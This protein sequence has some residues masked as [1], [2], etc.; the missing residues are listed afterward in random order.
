M[1]IS[2]AQKTITSNYLHLT[3]NKWLLV[4]QLQMLCHAGDNVEHA[5]QMPFLY[6]FHRL[7]SGIW[8][9]HRLNHGYTSQNYVQL[10]AV[11]KYLVQICIHS[12]SYELISYC[13]YIDR[14]LCCHNDNNSLIAFVR[15]RV[16]YF[17]QFKKKKILTTH[18]Q[19]NKKSSNG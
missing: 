12:S 15:C 7:L 6:I 2:K 18:C 13:W 10:W 19:N 14:F 11:W 17:C 16:K 5:Q 8:K 9:C 3:K 4:W 1:L